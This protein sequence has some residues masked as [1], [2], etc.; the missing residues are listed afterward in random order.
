[1]YFRGS[2]EKCKMAEGRTCGGPYESKLERTCLQ[3][4][5]MWGSQQVFSGLMK[6]YFKDFSMHPYTYIPFCTV[7]LSSH[8]CVIIFI[9]IIP[10]P[11]FCLLKVRVRGV[12]LI[13][14]AKHNEYSNKPREQTPLISAQLS[15]TEFCLMETLIT[16]SD[17]SLCILKR[18]KLC[19]RSALGCPPLPCM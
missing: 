11:K 13:S 14:L 7:S 17:I 1:M 4:T 8:L 15:T 12:V 9:K 18:M 6:G 10:E 2:S 16:K 19:A 5:E 3:P